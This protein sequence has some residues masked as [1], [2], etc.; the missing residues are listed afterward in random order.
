MGRCLERFSIEWDSVNDYDLPGESFHRGVGVEAWLGGLL[1]SERPSER[2][3]EDL[4]FH[5]TSNM[6][7]LVLGRWERGEGFQS[8]RLTGNF[9]EVLLG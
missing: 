7:E 5:R 1:V 9:R 2:P 3:W 6:K 4:L 8:A